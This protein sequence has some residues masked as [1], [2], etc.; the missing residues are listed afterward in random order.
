MTRLLSLGNLHVSDFV[1]ETLQARCSPSDLTL[2]LDKNGSARLET[3]VPKESMYGKYW[4]RSGT[5]DTMRKNLKSIVDSVLEVKKLHSGSIWLDIACNDGTLLSFVPPEVKRVGIDPADS[6]YLAESQKHGEIV[7]DF[8][9]VKAYQRSSV[10]EKKCDVITTIAMFYDLE[11]PGIFLDDI[12]ELLKDEGVWVM[13]LSYTPLMIEQ[14]AF[15]NICHEHVY[16][17]SLFNLQTLFAE[18]NMKIVDAQLNDV[19]GGS[20]RVFVMKEK[21]D[22]KNFAKQPHRD[23]CNF[24]VQSLL[25]YEKSLN[26]DSVATWREFSNRIE[27][28]KKQMNEFIMNERQKGKT[29]WAYG[30]STKGN[31]LLQYFG[32]NSE[33]IEA[34][35]ERNPMK[36]GLRTIGTNI[37]ICSENEMRKRRPDYL[38]VLPWH[39]IDEFVDREADYLR[40]GG[41]F[42]V[43]CPRFEIISWG[44]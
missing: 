11:E 41:K 30:A 21:A 22:V 32:L 9:S 1:D 35:A 7:Q 6:T 2:V 20:V 28:L 3:T 19:N 12:Y 16:Y 34:I 14:L 38:I 44:A 15:D 13:Q 5:N 25:A 10:A 31:T 26:L 43:P 18:H 27:S 8:F 33:S 42:V 17:Y 36:Y 39:F 40:Q 23:V 24:R 37:P 29:F 4:Y